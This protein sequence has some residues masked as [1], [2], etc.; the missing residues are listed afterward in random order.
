MAYHQEIS[1]FDR[2]QVE[3]GSKSKTP[4]IT[5]KGAPRMATFT[6]NI[7]P[8]HTYQVVVKTVS[9]SVAS[10]AAVGN[11]TTRPNP[12]RNLVV[13]TDEM[14][15]EIILSW[16]VDRESQQDSSKVFAWFGK[17]VDKRDCLRLYTEN[18]VYT[19]PEV[20]KP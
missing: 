17:Y 4:Q 7:K 11:V 8:G 20:R 13:E 2:Y 10:W 16:D 14:I 19:V 12:V 1:E 3:I 15:E 6:K 5:E 18:W 9:G